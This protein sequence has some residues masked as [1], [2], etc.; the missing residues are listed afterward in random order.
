VKKDAPSTSFRLSLEARKQLAK[1]AEHEER[2]QTK[3]LE[4]AIQE[5]AEKRGL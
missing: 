2:S 4:I 3:A 5:A 1:L